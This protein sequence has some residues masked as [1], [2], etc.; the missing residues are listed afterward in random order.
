[1]G[2]LR[3]A[4][5]GNRRGGRKPSP[6]WW[7]FCIKKIKA[8]M[9]KLKSIGSIIFGL[10]AVI[11]MISLAFT[12][13]YG[14]TYITVEFNPLLEKIASILVF[15]SILIL[16]PLA[17]FRKTRWISATGLYVFSYVFGL[18]TWMNGLLITYATLEIGRAHV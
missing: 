12:L 18:S 6:M 11:A 14:V 15:I 5:S 7:A 10:M 2:L 16:L 9:E 4:T 13:I 8:K 3:L 17:I 1:M